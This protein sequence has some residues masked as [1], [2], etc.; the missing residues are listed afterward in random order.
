MD[1]Q[2]YLFSRSI[3]ENIRLARQGATDTQVVEAC[4][5]AEIHDFIRG[6]N[7][8]YNTILQEGGV[9]VPLVLERLR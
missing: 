1:Q 9:Y 6:L 3:M 4:K 5:K 2:P 7:K 8:G